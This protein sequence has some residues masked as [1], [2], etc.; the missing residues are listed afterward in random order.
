MKDILTNS[1]KWVLITL[2]RIYQW[3]L[4]PLLG[5]NCR[6]YPTCSSYMIQAI[7]THGIIKGLWLGTKRLVKCGPWHDGGIDPVPGTECPSC[8]HDTH[9]H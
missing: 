4:S 5:K 8:D 1:I 3:T 2:V 6:F 9:T 7:E